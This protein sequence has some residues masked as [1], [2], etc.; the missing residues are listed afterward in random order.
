[1]PDFVSLTDYAEEKLLGH[2][3]LASTFTAP[4]TLW[5]AF[6]S[7]V[8]SD[9]NVFTELTTNTGYARQT[10]AFTP[11]IGD[12]YYIGSVNSVVFPTPTTPWADAVYIGLF[13]SGDIGSGNLLMWGYL[14]AQGEDELEVEPQSFHPGDVVGI[15][16]DLLYTYWGNPGGG[17]LGVSQYLGA[18]LNGLTLLGSAY[19]APA[20]V[21]VALATAGSNLSL[22]EVTTNTAYA[23]Q[24]LVG[25]ITTP[26]W[27]VI[28][29]AQIDFPEAT[30]PWGTV[31][32][33]GVYDSA[34]I[35]AGNLLFWGEVTAAQAVPAGD[36]ARVSVSSLTCRLT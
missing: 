14:T 25:F 28:N 33:I 13:D 23:R 29:T 20:T 3:L 36:S 5:L 34:T 1:M 2:T 12:P 16:P 18:K 6:A 10:A 21:W 31:T 35:G 30:T 7:S 24:P 15:I 9:G 11:F 32:H 22:T 27:T 8:T 4:S 26:A 19:T 17:E